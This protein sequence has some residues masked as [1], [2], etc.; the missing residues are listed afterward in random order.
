MLEPGMMCRGVDIIGQPE[1]FDPSEPLE[2]RMLH[3][4][5]NQLRRDCNEPVNRV[6]YGFYLIG[7]PEIHLILLKIDKIHRELQ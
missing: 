3:D 2:K 5:K 6:V 7:C 4:V 1:L